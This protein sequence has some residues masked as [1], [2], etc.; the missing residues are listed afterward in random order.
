LRQNF[1]GC[2]SSYSAANDGGLQNDYREV[3]NEAISLPAHDVC[4][5]SLAD[6]SEC[7]TDV[8]FTPK[9]DIVQPGGNVSFVRRQMQSSRPPKEIFRPPLKPLLI[10]PTPILSSRQV[11]LSLRMGR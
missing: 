2:R 6:I 8:R 10:R 7:P 9:G 4:F 1:H 11:T 5:G 3:Q